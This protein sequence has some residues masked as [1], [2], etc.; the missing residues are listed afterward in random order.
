VATI[1]VWIKTSA[2]ATPKRARHVVQTT[3]A[4]QRTQKGLSENVGRA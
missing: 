4:R 3:L 2:A 1:V